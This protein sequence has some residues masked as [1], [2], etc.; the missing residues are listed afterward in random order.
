MII[1]SKIGSAIRFQ[2]NLILLVLLLCFASSNQLYSQCITSTA[3]NVGSREDAVGC[4]GNKFWFGIF[5]VQGAPDGVVANTSS[6]DDGET[7][8]CINVTQYNFEVPCNATIT[9]VTVST[10]KRNNASGNPIDIFDRVVH[11]VLPD[12]TVSPSNEAKTTPWMETTTGWETSIYNGGLW[13]ATL[14]PDIVNDFRF[15]ALVSVIANDQ[16]STTDN[17]PEIDAVEIEICY[18][19]NGEPIDQF[20]VTDVSNTIATCGGTD[21][22]LTIDANNTSPLEYSLDGGAT[23]QTDN[24]F[25]DLGVGQYQY[26]LRYVGD[27]CPSINHGYGS[28][29]VFNTI[30]QPGDAILACKTDTPTDPTLVVDKVQPF[31]DFY[32]AGQV[33]VD[34]SSQIDESM[35]W[36][37]VDLGGDVFHVTLDED[38]NIY[39]GTTALYNLLANRTPNVLKIDGVTGAVS[40]LTT[41]PG[42]WGIGAVEYDIIND[43]LFVVNMD[44][45]LIYRLDPISGA[46][47]STFDHGPADNGDTELA[48]LGDRI[49]G[50]TYNQCDN[51]IY[52][53]VWG[54]DFIQNGMQNEIWSV[55]L[56]AN[57]EF[58]ASTAQLEITTPF[59]SVY[60]GLANTD[61]NQPVADI[62]FDRTCTKILLSEVGYDSDF[63]R[64]KA[65]E[66]RLLQ[67]TGSGGSWTLINNIPAGN[68]NM[69]FEIGTIR[70]G[71]NSRG[72]TDW[73]YA[74]TNAAGCP[75]GEDQFYV[76]TADAL[77]GTDCTFGDGCLYGLQYGPID[78]SNADNSVLFD[79]ARDNSSQQ[80]SVF[81]D[82]D[83]VNGPCCTLYD[84]ALVKQFMISSDINMDGILSAGDD[85]SYTIKVFNQGTIDAINI[86]ITDYIPTDMT[87][88]PNDTN[89]WVGGPSGNVTNIIPQ[90]AANTYEEVFIVLRIDPNF[91]G[92]TIVNTAE[93]SSDDGDDVDST[94]NNE[95]ADDVIGGNDLLDS[96]N[97]D[98]DDHDIEEI[99]L[100]IPPCI[101]PTLTT[102]SIQC[103]I[104]AG[105][106]SVIFYSSI[107]D[108]TT[109]AGVISGSTVANIPLGT[110]L[111]LTAIYSDVCTTIL[112]VT[113]PETCFGPEECTYPELTVG[114]PVCNG[115]GTYFVSYTLV[116]GGT[117]NATLGT[118]SGNSITGIPV[119][120]N[121][122]ITAT[123]GNCVSEVTV[124]GMITC[125]DPCE[126]P[127]ASLSGPYCEVGNLTYTIDFAASSLATITS[128]AGIVGSNSITGISTG[129]SV[130]VTI[131]Y[132]DCP[133]R[134]VTV[135]SA[136]C[137]VCV[138]PTLTAGAIDCDVDSGTYSFIFYSSSA[139][140]TASAG[141]VNGFMVENIPLGTDVTLVS[142][143]SMSC[144]TTLEVTGPAACFGPEECT[145][146]EL[147]VGQPVCNGD[148]T[149]FISYT[150]VG[151]G[152]PNATLGTISGN[153][154]TGIPVGQNT[155]ITATDGNCVTEVTV[156]CM[157]TCDD[158][159]ENPGA[160]LSGPYCE[161]GNLTYA[162]DYVAASAATVT[163]N[164]GTVG[165]TSITGIPAGTAI[166]ITISYPNCADRVITVPSA[167]CEVCE[168]PTLTAGAIECNATS[169]TYSV[170]FYSSSS[171]VSASAGNISGFVVENIPLGTDLTLT[172]SF[173]SSCNTILEVSGPSTCY[174][175]EECNY[176]EL[177]VGQAVCNGDG[178]YFISYTLVGGGTPTASVGTVGAN[179]I[180]GI[181]LGINVAV[182]ASDGNCVTEVTVT[183][184]DNC[185]NPCENPGAS[186][187]GPYCEIGNLTYAVDYIAASAATVTS[188]VGTVGASSITGI[189]SGTIVEI[190]ISYP[191]CADKIVSVPS[192]DCV[193]CNRPILT[194]GAIDCN[195][196]AGTYSAIFYSSTN[197]VTTSAG[198]INGFVVE[199]IPL[200]TNAII[201]AS[202][203][204]DCNTIL[205][206]IAPTSCF[207]PSE[208]LYPELTVGQAVCNG[209]GTY[210]VSY[211]LPGGG[212]PTSTSGSVGANVITGIALGTD[213]T[214]SA[215]DGNC[216]TSVKVLGPDN[217]ANPCENPGV[218]LSGP[219]CEQGQNSYM[220]NFVAASDATV[221]SNLGTVS[222]GAITGIPSGT[223]AIITVSRPGCPDRV[224]TVPFANCIYDLMLIKTLD[225]HND[226]NN[227][228]SIS[229][230]DE[231]TF[232]IS[233]CNEGTTTA[234]QVTIQDYI[235]TGLILA[236]PDWTNN[237]GIAE[238]NNALMVAVG[239]SGVNCANVP[240][241]FTIDPTFTGTTITNVAEIADDDGDDIDST[242][243]NDVDEEDDQDD[244]TINITQVYDLA[245]MKSFFEFVDSNSNGAINSGEDVT[246]VI[247]ILNEGGIIANNIQISDHIPLGMNLST[248]DT[249]GWTGGPTGTVTN[250]VAT[251]AANG[252]M[253]NIFITLTIDPTFMGTEL[254]NVAEIIGDDGDDTDSTPG[255]GVE[256][257]DDQDD[258]IIPIGQIYDLTLI[259]QYD[260]YN[261]VDGSGD[262]SPGD[263]VS[264]NITVC[265]QGSLDAAQ[266][267][268]VDYIPLGLILADAGWSDSDGD[269]IANY[270]TNL[271]I[272]A[273]A[274]CQVISIDFNIHPDFEGTTIVNAAEISGDDGDDMDST[275]DNDILNDMFGGDDFTDNMNGDEDDHDI[276]EIEI[277]LPTGSIS[278]EVWKD[279]D[280]DGIQDPDETPVAG[281]TVNLYDCSGNLIDSTVSGA[282]GAYTF[283]GL[284]LGDYMVIFDYD[285]IP[286]AC[287]PTLVDQG[288]DD[289]IDSDGGPD[290]STP[291]VSLGAGDDITDIDLGL[292]PVETGKLGNMVWIDC[293][294]NGIMDEGEEG[295]G[296]VKV[297]LTNDTWT[298]LGTQLTDTDGKYLFD[299]LQPG[300]Y[301]V[302]FELPAGYEATLP[303]VGA[304]NTIDSD[305]DHSNGWYST[306]FY[307][308][309]P[310]E[311]D[312]DNYDFGLYECI[313]VGDQVW[314]DTNEN[315]VWD[316]NENGINQLQVV[317]WKEVGPSKF[318]AIDYTYTG[319]KPGTA[320][321][322]G[323][324]KFCIAPGTYY[325]EFVQP[326]FGLVAATADIGS[327]EE[328]DSD[329]TNANGPGTTDTFTVV[330]G[331]EVCDIGAGYYPMGTVGDY[332]WLDGN[333][334]GLRDTGETGVS[335]VLVNA[336]DTS[337]EMVGSST[338]DN[339]GQYMIDY[340]RQSDVYLQFNPPSGYGVTLPNMG[341][342]DSD[343]DID[344]SNGP[345]TT[346]YYSITPGNHMANVDAGLIFGSVPLDWVDFY[347]KNVGD[348]NELKWLVENELNVSHYEVERKIEAVDGF[349][350]VGTILSVGDND[351]SL[352][353]Y[354]FSDFDIANG[355][356]YLYRIKQVD[357]DGN[358][359]YS[360]VISISVNANENLT[361]SLY[362]NPTNKE[363]TFDVQLNKNI[364]DLMYD[365]I[366]LDGKVVRQQTSLAKDLIQGRHLFIIDVSDFIEGTYTFKFRADSSVWTKKLIVIR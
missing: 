363:F 234:N 357:L 220:M 249:N 154:I 270:N 116:G 72:G 168:K 280:E 172:A 221:S 337:G 21:G 45:G 331:D 119:G 133:D 130:D 3:G 302:Q 176:P 193:A 347:G 150:L 269:G 78:G 203:G 175:P 332:V 342:D 62:E 131:S 27:L 299:N 195:A 358:E 9:S 230:N 110:N 118:V 218:S 334:N 169:G 90:V 348:H 76:V 6:I 341:N 66:G 189:P 31:G 81:G 89:G 351:P 185:A 321:D 19:V 229:L 165:A 251:V 192:A 124:N 335:G 307:R 48:P 196:A 157:I 313:E 256:E 13:G 77:Q 93:I 44:D 147:T 298:V 324:F 83:I 161:I 43:Q 317:L 343:S 145:Y 137:M 304:D 258:A 91:T 239:G 349:N 146:P 291:C 255:N 356:E 103:D 52:Y 287:A 216:V 264:F 85:I 310:G 207:T 142:S 295:L 120:Q 197:S 286:Q 312:L 235:P 271:A 148:G 336:Y 259:K 248:N 59:L 282:D 238:Y 112:E 191:E 54:N 115:D 18:S 167:D 58:I 8:K 42:A 113:G 226:I 108:V 22:C 69:Q 364:S 94:P 121:T 281:V 262:I 266:I 252:G 107:S 33:G 177:T 26:S 56:D 303:N 80:K 160:S 200:G 141:T 28:V 109:S 65:H 30:L 211:T 97:G 140:V 365:V 316:S 278:G 308:L 155:T 236:D 223:S 149:Y 136:D 242:P 190:T 224:I 4:D 320:S 92:T 99:T 297:H 285:S 38:Y 344:G 327:D 135:P 355:N 339:N 17:L 98:E 250:T 50:M 188:N 102:G 205:E 10:T 41:L 74:G 152:T 111:I 330:C 101:K 179:S 187:S 127:G 23:W 314:Y 53:A 173:S 162:V 361:A 277:V 68:S 126:N 139:N 164:A 294:G 16:S 156:N 241:T 49:L 57:G 268:I 233:V 219:I 360:D 134:V 301:F 265:N 75:S 326:P 352:L 225:S 214:V 246:F 199:N 73:A 309:E 366:G 306:A 261:D 32:S 151:G 194:A 204:T 311:C 272:A 267:E 47:M 215:S 55:A 12:G 283:D 182:S 184:P 231:V 338:T 70:Q 174:G 166:Q 63:P 39:T 128:N 106:Y 340:L 123:D 86:E 186:L 244:E 36:S 328:I 82:V 296:G 318:I 247:T 84:L 87:L 206:V 350:V 315:N 290:G 263:E 24:T 237:N 71:L 11:L 346:P 37:R 105:T 305:V 279:L 158:P 170:D 227:D 163:A 178:T 114:Q 322:D 46:T 144:T 61:Y 132:P 15:G 129:M 257:E 29:D 273:G 64:T 329:I 254:T 183:G 79:S 228:G 159:C 181:P 212:T 2:R 95:P 217:C 5:N 345:M 260:T 276:A 117:P 323:Y 143:F 88:S 210:F 138:K 325:L 288:T 1:N 7:S 353:D 213:I 14:T 222:A 362:P 275:A 245:L 104:D 201:T 67:Y 240:I 208:C 232:N 34:V 35:T 153:S 284:A 209:D 253:E 125:D 198:N 40:T 319:H 100:E 243:D 180:T 20:V 202:N 51:R 25:C 333:G 274:D 292:I 300:L 60:P 359:S 171:N 293:N 96:S 289:T 354:T 122:T